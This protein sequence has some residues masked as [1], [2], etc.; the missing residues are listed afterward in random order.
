MLA[1]RFGSAFFIF[2][3]LYSLVFAILFDAYNLPLLVM[4]ALSLLTAAGIHLA[5]RWGLWLAFAFSPILTIIAAS[6]F[7]VSATFTGGWE[8]LVFRVSLVAILAMEVLTVLLL[9]DKR[10]DF[11]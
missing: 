10:R 4:T 7:L 8:S 3:G 5:K 11:N 1:S 2:V 9:L 6:P